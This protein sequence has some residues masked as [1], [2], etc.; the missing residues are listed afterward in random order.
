MSLGSKLGLTAKQSF[1]REWGVEC[2]EWPTYSSPS[3]RAVEKLL[4]KFFDEEEAE[5]LCARQALP[6]GFTLMFDTE[7]RS[8]KFERRLV[9]LNGDVEICRMMVQPHAFTGNHPQA[10]VLNNGYLALRLYYGCTGC[11]SL[12]RMNGV[13]RDQSGVKCRRCGKAAIR[14]DEAKPKEVKRYV[15]NAKSPQP[16]FADEEVDSEFDE[17]EGF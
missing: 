14:L 15:E 6:R 17:A 3:R 5:F 8:E 2:Y 13:F 10:Q 4:F 1:I 11:Q 7:T 12:R 9:R 16:E